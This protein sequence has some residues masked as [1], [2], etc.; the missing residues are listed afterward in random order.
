MTPDEFFR[1]DLAIYIIRC[2]IW[3]LFQL[4]TESDNWQMTRM[5]KN[6]RWIIFIVC[7]RKRTD[8]VIMSAQIM[9]YLMPIGYCFLIWFTGTFYKSGRVFLLEIHSGISINLIQIRWR[10]SDQFQGMRCILFSSRCGWS[11]LWVWLTLRQ[12][13]EQLQER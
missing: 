11:D 4:S 1:A 2:S 12:L 3:N 7:K 5:Q 9:Q 8:S 6:G 10:I 13:Q